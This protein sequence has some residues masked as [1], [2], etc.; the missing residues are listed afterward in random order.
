VTRAHPLNGSLVNFDV[1]R[2]LCLREDRWSSLSDG[3][4][5]A[6][7]LEGPMQPYNLALHRAVYTRPNSGPL[8]TAFQKALE[9]P[10][11]ISRFRRN[12]HFQ[13]YN[14]HRAMG[15]PTSGSSGDIR[16]LR[17]ATRSR[18]VFSKCRRHA[19]A[20]GSHLRRAT[21]LNR[22]L[23]FGVWGWG[24]A[25]FGVRAGVR[26]IHAPRLQTS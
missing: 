21:T 16:E 14:S 5:K 15:R 17:A 22:G 23:G 3:A 13:V 12:T 6:T 20:L 1:P 26:R 18:V 19:V 25:G 10:H 11:V 7:R 4:L 24:L 8:R 2:H 9:T